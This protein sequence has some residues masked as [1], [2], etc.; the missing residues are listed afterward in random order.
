MVSNRASRDSNSSTNRI[1]IAS[2]AVWWVVS[3]LLAAAFRFEFRLEEVLV[4]PMFWLGVALASIGAA[5]G[6]FSHLYRLRFSV[7]SI[8]ELRALAIT[9]AVPGIVGAFVTGLFGGQFS[10]PRSA[11]F[12]AVPIFALLA[13]G[14][15]AFLRFSR[16]VNSGRGVSSG[17]R[18]AIYGA[19]D[20][21]D[22][23]IPQLL[24]QDAVPYHPVALIDDSPAKGN[25]WIRGVPMAGTWAE[26][27]QIA[28][29]YSLSTV[30]LAIP[31]ADSALVRR[32]YA[33]ASSLGLKVVVLPSL[34]EYL[35]G[36]KSAAD[37]RA[38]SIEDL[39]GRQS[40]GL[41]SGP[42]DR[43]IRGKRVLVTG[44]G[45]SIGTELSRQISHFGPA[46]LVLAD[47][48]ETGLLSAFSGVSHDGAS[49]SCVQYLIDIR[50]NRVV[51]EM[52][53]ASK[54]D[55][56]FHAAAL[57]HLPIL[58]AFPRE[59]WKTNVAGTINLLQAAEDAAVSVFVNISTDKAA[60]PVSYL[61]RSKLLGERLTAWFGAKLG[62]P[63]VSVRF[64]NVLG[65]RGSLIPII[66][67]QISAGGPVTLTDELATRYFMSIQ[68]ACQL[69]L[70][71]AAHGDQQDV[72]VLD[73]GHP[74]SIKAIAERMIELSGASVPIRYMGLR[75]GE[76]LH[77]DLHS[78]D[79]QWLES[80]LPKI[81]R[82]KSTSL[83]PD[84]LGEGAW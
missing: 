43:L 29:D 2:D 25:R 40:V 78:G 21:A 61:G 77:E 17:D 74:V 11:V 67:E 20:A 1:L 19:G 45:G 57:K 50:D 8:D 65:S 70:Q 13:G 60:E 34:R 39:L 42:V 49:S 69:V 38:V 9:I 80:P 52:L 73:M 15:R 83:S 71:A 59:A 41:D 23:L 75:P 24:G 82:F 36:R 26:I 31:S 72:M 35:G 62:R 66:S 44:A 27:G 7:A 18:A 56:V 47:R 81:M 22:A 14:T 5:T 48:D 6:Y 54:P 63:Y 30:I 51:Q 53:E 28:A 12:I 3:A 46:A 10:V 58:E 32:V 84:D 64:G 33:D 76:K 79:E 37:L 16:M 55:V 4:V 68:E